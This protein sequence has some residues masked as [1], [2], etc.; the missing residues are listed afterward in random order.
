MR[1]IIVGAGVIG[2]FLAK[3]LAEQRIDTIV[4]ESKSRI[5]Q[6]TAKASGIFSIDGFAK[7]GVNPREAMVN[8]LNGAHIYAGGER[9]DIISKKDKAY[10]LD[11]GKLAE[12]CMREAERAGAKIILGKRLKKE[13]II[14]LSK[15]SENIMVGADG[16]VS[17]VASALGF[18]AIKEHILTYKAEYEMATGNNGM[19]IDKVNLFFSNKI[20]KRFF[21]WTVPYSNGKLEI[22]IGISS[23][24]KETSTMA[25]DKFLEIEYMRSMITGAKKTAGYASIIPLE[26]RAKTVSRNAILVGDAAGQVKATT[27]GG[28]IFGV[29]CAEV[30]ASSIKKYVEGKAPLEHYEKAWRRMYGADLRLHRMFHEYYSHTNEATLGLMIRTAKVLGL[31]RFLGEYGD[32]DSPKLIIKRFVLR[33]FAK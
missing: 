33:G 30:A 25:F 28:I 20:A 2:L 11:R 29:A 15:D 32:M 31:D 16:A 21:G 26:A 27:G 24:S 5:S 6:D 12:I 18:P 19:E 4:Y 13:D 9:L 17:T 10:V 14:E 1:V 22:G 7:L 8:M 3:R 23:R